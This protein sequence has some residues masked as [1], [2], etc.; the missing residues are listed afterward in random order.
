MEKTSVTT[1]VGRVVYDRKVHKFTACDLYR[2][3]KKLPVP[4]STVPILCAIEATGEFIQKLFVGAGGQTLKIVEAFELELERVRTV[5][6]EGGTL[7]VAVD[8]PPA[9][10]DRGLIQQLWYDFWRGP[11]QP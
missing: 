6:N 4:V 10:P 5:V 11:I 9:E 8:R 1:V 2:M 3:L 7:A